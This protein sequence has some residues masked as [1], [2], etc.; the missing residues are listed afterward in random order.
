[1]KWFQNPF[2][3]GLR[4]R[5]KKACWQ[6][7]APG[8]IKEN[9]EYAEMC[10]RY[11]DDYDKH[12]KKVKELEEELY[13][14]RHFYSRMGEGYWHIHIGDNV[15]SVARIDEKFIDWYEKWVTPIQKEFIFEYERRETKEEKKKREQ[16]YLEKHD[17]RYRD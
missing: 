13:D 14:E 16:T 2:S 15:S 9:R 7:V 11:F 4:W 3:E 6:I 1:M 8:L 5:F 17:E 12:E 10:D